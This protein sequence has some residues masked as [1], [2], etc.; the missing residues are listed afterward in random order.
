M[1]YPIVTA[2]DSLPFIIMNLVSSQPL[3][4]VISCVT[5]ENNLIWWDS[6]SDYYQSWFTPMP[7]E[8]LDT[9]SRQKC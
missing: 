3:Y 7:F 5:C 2:G 9:L 4:F 1:L 6:L 8:S